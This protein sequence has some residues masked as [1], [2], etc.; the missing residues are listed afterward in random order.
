[1]PYI[2]DVKVANCRLFMNLQIFLNTYGRDRFDFKLTCRLLNTKSPKVAK[3]HQ[4]WA[5]TK[6]EWREIKGLT[7]EMSKN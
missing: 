1:M 6:T 7:R 3:E 2:E 4:R 5:N